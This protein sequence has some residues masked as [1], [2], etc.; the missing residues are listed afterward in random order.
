MERQHNLNAG[1][2]IKQASEWIWGLLAN[3]GKDAELTSLRTSFPA[4]V[5]IVDG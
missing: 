4:D 2:K 5:R 3:Y 1:L